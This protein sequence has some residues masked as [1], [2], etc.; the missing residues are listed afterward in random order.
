MGVQPLERRFASFVV[1]EEMAEAGAKDAVELKKV[2]MVSLWS[3]EV[4]VENCGICKESNHEVCINCLADGLTEGCDIAIGECNHAFHWHCIESW[5]KRRTTCPL[6]H[7]EW[8]LAHRTE[9]RST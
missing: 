9:Q 1:Q 7:T 6:D 8:M 4:D 3:W 2:Q 5:L